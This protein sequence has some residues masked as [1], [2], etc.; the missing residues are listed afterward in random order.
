[1]AVPES[2]DL[3]EDCSLLPFRSIELTTAK[4]M[5]SWTLLCNRIACQGGLGVFGS[6]AI[7]ALND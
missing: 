5:Q 6:H 2:D 1:M 4:L 3:S 7:K